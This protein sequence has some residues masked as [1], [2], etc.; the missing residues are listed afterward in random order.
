MRRLLRCLVALLA[1]TAAAV[2]VVSAADPARGSAILDVRPLGGHQ[3]QVTVYSAAMNRPITL[4]MSHPD[5]PAP[6]LYLLNAVDG[7]EDGGPWNVRTDAARFFADKP[8]NVV[9]PIGGRA[10][11]YTDWA[12]ADPV[13]GRNEWSTF[14]NRELPPL[15]AGRFRTTGRNAVAGVSM[16]GASAL[17]LAIDAPGMY[18]AVGAYSPSP[19]VSDPAMTSLVY[20]QLATFGAN[21]TNMWGPPGSPGWAAHDPVVNAARLRGTALFISAGTG[22]SGPHENITDASIAGN[23]LTLADRAGVGGAMEGMVNGSTHTLT[24]RLA[25]LGIPATVDYRP[26]THSWPYWQDALHNSWPVFARALGV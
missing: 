19:N 9:V 17:D 18:Q 25:A 16:S 14:L 1:V 21:A 4:W 2:P 15:L 8:V 10:S 3:Y 7:G 20:S 22:G 26:G 13:L 23:P 5:R 6:L 24:D 12:S 11:Y